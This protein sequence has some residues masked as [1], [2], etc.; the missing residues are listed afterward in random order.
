MSEVPP[1]DEEVAL[2]AAEEQD[3]TRIVSLLGLGERWHVLTVTVNVGEDMGGSE[4]ERKGLV[5]L[6]P[7]EHEEWIWVTEEQVKARTDAEGRTI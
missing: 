5:K 2:A 7:D 4:A 1:V 3:N 6:R